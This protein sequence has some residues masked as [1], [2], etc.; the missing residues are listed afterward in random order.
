L[1]ASRSV[2]TRKTF[3]LFFNFSFF[4]E[5]FRFL[6]F[7]CFHEY[8]LM[9][10]S[11]LVWL[12][13]YKMMIFSFSNVL[14]LFVLLVGR[15]FWFLIWFSQFSFCLEVFQ[16]FLH[17]FRQLRIFHY[18]WTLFFSDSWD[19]HLTWVSSHSFLFFVRCF[20]SK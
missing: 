10:N 9:I 19:F 5:C 13:V 1:T 14:V 4:C 3:D 2:S 17:P 20:T 15:I 6:H 7:F 11:L 12:C 18:F 8:F 16:T